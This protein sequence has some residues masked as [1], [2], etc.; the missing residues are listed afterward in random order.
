M[1]SQ[2]KKCPH[3]DSTSTLP[4]AYGLMSDE[5]HK[6]NNE[7]RE[8]VWGGCKFG[9]IGTDFCEDCNECFGEVISYERK[10]NP[11]FEKLRAEFEEERK[12]RLESKKPK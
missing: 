3:C 2:I 4:I 11:Y 12:Q 5:V 10:P 7:S 8:W 1:K 9:E 6:K